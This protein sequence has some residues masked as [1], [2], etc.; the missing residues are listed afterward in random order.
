MKSAATCIALIAILSCFFSAQAIAKPQQP[1]VPVAWTS[2]V[3]WPIASP[4]PVL[5]TDDKI[6][7]VYELLVMNV[8]SS[9]MMLDRLEALDASKDDAGSNTKS[10]DAIVAT[11]QGADLEATIRA[12]P[13]GSTRTIGPFQLTRIFLDVKFAKDATLPK[14]LTHRFQVTF[15]PATGT[16]PLNSSTIVSGRTD[17]TNAAAIVIGPPLEG[18]RWVDALGCCSPP[19]GHRTATLPI[20]GKFVCFERFAIDFAQLNP[21]NKLYAGPRDQLSSYAYVGAKVLAVADGTVV[22]LQD[23]RPEE[24]PPNF[25]KGYD[26]MQQLGNFVIIDIGHGHFAFYAHFQPNTLKVHKGDKVRRGQELAL[27]GNSGNSDAPH[28]HFGI[29]DGPLPF[30]SNGV[31]FVFSSFTTTGT[32]TNPF[33]DIAAGATAQIGPARAGPHR[34]ELPLSDDVIT[35]PKQ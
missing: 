35:F 18:P 4:Q 24:T 15:A 26:L 29:E 31:P 30:A 6:H 17:V 8:S 13:T 25:P 5:C 2:L 1:D 14:V 34:N 3:A 19:S 9:A 32:I 20:N 22:N 12:F 23:N 21:E 27:L 16:P 10:G 33:D 28:L 7:L 11:L